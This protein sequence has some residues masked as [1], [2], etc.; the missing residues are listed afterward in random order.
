MNLRLLIFPFCWSLLL[1]TCTFGYGRDV[2]KNY[3]N[4]IN[5]ASSFIDWLG[6]Y[7]SGFHFFGIYIGVILA[8]FALSLS[9]FLLLH[10]RFGLTLSQCVL[11]SIPLLLSWPIITLSLNAIRQGLLTSALISLI[12]YAYLNRTANAIRVFSFSIFSISLHSAGILLTISYASWLA[13]NKLISVQQLRSR[14]LRSIL[15]FFFLLFSIATYF[16][17]SVPSDYVSRSV[18]ID[19]SLMVLIA[20]IPPVFISVLKF[21]KANIYIEFHDFSL[22]FFWLVSI[23]ALFSGLNLQVERLALLVFPCALSVLFDTNLFNTF[24]KRFLFVSSIAVISFIS[25]FYRSL[26]FL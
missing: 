6:F 13:F 8:S 10:Y 16:S 3:S 14:L 21:N 1:G 17:F 25:P 9:I 23:A 20:A 15:I 12:L 26:E 4:S 18:G 11:V 24:L 7:L 2:I 19:V 5:Y 22:V